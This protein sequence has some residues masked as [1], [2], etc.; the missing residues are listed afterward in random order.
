MKSS[1]K[2]NKITNNRNNKITDYFHKTKSIEWKDLPVQKSIS[3]V[4]Q[5]YNECL[6]EEIKQCDGT[7]CVNR[8]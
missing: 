6:A 8:N 1:S 5:F 2:H 4:D 7:S 3:S